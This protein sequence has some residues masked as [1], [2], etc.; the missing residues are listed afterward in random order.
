MQDGL[1]V[2]SPVTLPFPADDAATLER[3]T[4]MTG[5]GM[6]A[7]VAVAQ[8]TQLQRVRMVL[9]GRGGPADG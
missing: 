4:H 1:L 6:E 2:Q 3:K 9:C 8:A 5:A 7:A